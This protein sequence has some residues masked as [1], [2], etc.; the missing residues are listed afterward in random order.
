MTI[1]HDREAITVKRL[2]AFDD[3]HQACDLRMLQGEVDGLTNVLS[4][5]TNEDNQ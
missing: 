3:I 2:A 5:G 1:F 4:F